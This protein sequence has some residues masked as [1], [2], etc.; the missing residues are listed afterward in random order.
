[1]NDIKEN[2]KAYLD[3]ELSAENAERVRSALET[4]ASLREEAEFMRALSASFRKMQTNRQ[5]S[6]Q[7]AAVEKASAR[8]IH[9]ALSPAGL[10][11]AAAALVFVFFVGKALLLA[12]R[13]AERSEIAVTPLA[14][15]RE[16][17]LSKESGANAAKSKPQRSREYLK[18][19]SWGG[20][21]STKA[22]PTER[23][24][25]ADTFMP[26]QVVRNATVKMRVA[27]IQTAEDKVTLLVTGW[28]GYI[29]DSQ[30]ANSESENPTVVMVLRI[31]V[32][33]FDEAI[34]ELEKLG[35]RRDR[36]INGRD[37]TG[38]VVDIQAR[39][40]NLRMQE[41][42]YRQILRQA[43][44][45]GE[46]LEIQQQIYAV[47]GEIE[48]MD[49]EL[50]SLKKLAALSTITL[51]LEQ[52]PAGGP[53]DQNDSGWASDAWANATSGLSSALKALSTAA[54]WMFVY[55]PIWAPLVIAVWLI[56]K[57]ASRKTG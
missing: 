44:R 45:I 47:R 34:S 36:R 25:T 24:M 11:S 21:A 30:S 10:A 6:G 54:I 13:R 29:E 52:R 7:A 16:T 37:V 5:V 17:A 20:P 2:L 41:E 32:S 46:V 48:S 28:G 4:D 31:P 33:R 49:A 40:K 23:K 9:W 18:S 12:P 15:P 27:K 56:S 51:T 57:W 35:V 53:N 14:E 19:P 55:S 26:R 50:Q 39:L 43:R 38:E 3:G 42:A 22:A 1:M 8:K